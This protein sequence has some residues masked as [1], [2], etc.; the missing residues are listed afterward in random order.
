MI[1][2]PA[3]AMISRPRRVACGRAAAGHDLGVAEHPAGHEHAPDAAA[4]PELVLDD[5]MREVVRH[6]AGGTT[7]AVVRAAVELHGHARRDAASTTGSAASHRLKNSI[8]V[9]LIVH[10]LPRPTLRSLIPDDCFIAA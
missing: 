6:L 9:A 10:W 3:A 1:S 7:H 4:Q 2:S 8:R 5:E